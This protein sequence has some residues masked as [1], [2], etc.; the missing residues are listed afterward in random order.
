MNTLSR[1]GAVALL[2]LPLL[3][4]AQSSYTLTTLKPG[5][6]Q[7]GLGSSDERMFIDAKNRVLGNI[8]MTGGWRSDPALGGLPAPYSVSYIAQW[9]VPASGTSVT[10]TK[11]NAKQGYLRLAS[12]DGDKIVGEAGFLDRAV[13][14]FQ[15]MAPATPMDLNNATQMAG[16]YWLAPPAGVNVDANHS[17]AWSRAA[18]WVQ[19][20]EPTTLPVGEQ[21][22]GASAWA[23]NDTGTVVGTVYG[24]HS[25]L[26][27]R[28]A[29]WVNG[30]LEVLDQQPNKGSSAIDVNNA[31]QVLLMQWDTQVM[32][33]QVPG[34]GLYERV[35][36]VNDS[37]AV[38]Q[39]GVLKPI[40]ASL[41]GYKVFSARAINA[42]GTVIGVMGTDFPAGVDP[43]TVARKPLRAFLWKDGVM[44]DLTTLV[45]TKGVKLPAGAILQNI[46][47]INDQGSLVAM[48]ENPQNQRYVYVR[49]LAKP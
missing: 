38:L 25:R 37:Y 39:N 35:D 46:V 22:V 12:P 8:T 48:Y 21:F 34:I 47:A 26:N 31:G 14:K 33:V 19:G 40:V 28:A 9:A 1:L 24:E 13:N 2:T 27:M 6:L 23:L 15:A 18:V 29:R 10:S 36:F 30:V 17:A 7:S 5:F 16:V 41:K 44:S 4:Q 45:A 3:S 43:S 42:T 49:L 20:K 32:P 11:L